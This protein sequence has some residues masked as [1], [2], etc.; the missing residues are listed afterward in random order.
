MTKYVRRLDEGYDIPDERYEK[1]LGKF[2]DV[3]P[4]CNYH[5]NRSWLL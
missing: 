2:V 3:C 5:N 4:L 1:W